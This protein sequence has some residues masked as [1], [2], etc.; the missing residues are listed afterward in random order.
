MDDA[1]AVERVSR[2]PI[3]VPRED[4]VGL[5]AINASN[6]IVEDRTAG[7]LGAFGLL[8]ALGYEVVFSIPVSELFAGMREAVEPEIEKHLDQLEESL[9]RRQKGR[10]KTRRQTLDWLVERR[11]FMSNR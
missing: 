11:Q 9:R 4:S 7:V 10:W 5:A 3:R 2:E 6:H 8:A 1:T